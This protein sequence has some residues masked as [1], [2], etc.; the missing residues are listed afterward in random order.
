MDLYLLLVFA[1]FV[2]ELSVHCVSGFNTG[3]TD[4][5]YTGNET[6]LL[7]AYFHIIRPVRIPYT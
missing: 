3:F 1:I 7:I 5:Q 6:R 4:T 2:G